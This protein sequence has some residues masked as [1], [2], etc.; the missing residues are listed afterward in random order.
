[1]LKRIRAFSQEDSSEG[2][3]LILLIMVAVLLLAWTMFTVHLGY[4]SMWTDEWFSWMYS[5]MGPIKLVTQ[6]AND[7]HP[8]FYYQVLWAW[9]TFT[10]S[11]NLFMMRLT[12]AFPSL[13][14][15]AVVYRLG[16][17]WFRSRWAG[18]GAAVFLATSG[19][20]IYYARELRMYALMV[21][22]AVLS[23]WLLTHWLHGRK[24]SLWGYA[25]CV[26]LMVY[27]YYF[28]VFVLFAQVI[29]VA[30]FYRRK[31]FG[32]FKAY[33]VALIAFAPWI[34]TL[35][36]QMFYERA[37]TGNPNAA[38]LG[39]FAATSPTNLTTISQFVGHYTADQPAFVLL[40]IVLALGLGWNAAGKETRR[41]L[42]AAALWLGL[43]AALMFGL[44]L[45]FPIY[46]PRYLLTIMPGL[47][48]LVGVTIYSLS[49]QR[50]V[51]VAAAL[52]GVVAV[53][54]VMSHAAAF[55]PPKT[56]HQD[57]LRTISAE[58]RPGDR[59]WYNFSYGGLGS[60][61]KE[62][63]AYH[64]K[65]DAPNITSDDFV[66]DAPNDYADPA[67]VPR[68]WDVRPY[69]I[70]IPD[71]AKAPLVSDRALAEDYVFGAYEVRLYE[72][73]PTNEPTIQIGDVF[74]LLPGGVQMDQYQAGAKVMVNSWWQT[75]RLPPLDYSYVL[76]L[77]PKGG[78]QVLAQNDAGLLAAA[79]T[80]PTSQWTPD[81]PYRLTQQ[82]ITLPE[83]L[84]PGTYDLWLGV[85]FWQNPQRLPAQTAGATPISA[86]GASV[87]IG[88]VTVV[89]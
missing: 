79:D 28:S 40:L 47:A 45:E 27:T 34:P 55:L 77:K 78:D 2:T 50:R 53:S 65:F 13:L 35:L 29:I 9:D 83:N 52:I 72:A 33:A 57:M 64:L 51:G 14:T 15:V 66:W 17:E 88:Q 43:T 44:N 59:I 20:F 48:L 1:M 4:E 36:S 19:F 73:P 80:T 39:K 30:W 74:K 58:F 71:K 3:L 16:Y 63:V 22:L 86:D 32:L 60:S 18:I 6:T 41:W 23:W 24:R 89:K 85:Y 62:E 75:T 38:P 84:A 76:Y 54:G 70:P 61:I 82:S 8:P 87:Q 25:A 37:R 21:L 11:Q 5:I 31:L 10:G 26:G 69:W 56:P 7:V 42:I 67:K 49:Q 81:Q 46:N 68:V 12:A